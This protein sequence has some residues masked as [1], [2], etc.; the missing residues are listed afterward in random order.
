MNVERRHLTD[1]QRAAVAG[2]LVTDGQLKADEAADRV[3][4]SANQASKARRLAGHSDHLV[5][6]IRSGHMSIADGMDVIRH[7][8]SERLVDALEAAGENLTTVQRIIAEAKEA[9]AEK[10]EAQRASLTLTGDRAWKHVEFVFDTD[11]NLLG[12]GYVR[13]RAP[14][15]EDI[16]PHAL[17]ARLEDVVDRKMRADRS[18]IRKALRAELEEHELAAMYYGF[19]NVVP[20]DGM[21]RAKITSSVVNR[22]V[23]Y[24]EADAEDE[25][26]DSDDEDEDE[27]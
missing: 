7:E 6:L 8:D 17:V 13:E 2:K 11:G 26:D 16:D 24:W 15:P 22:L 20:A 1:D 4:V 27:D 10:R 21:G 25:D 19:E 12:E 23:S 9:R 18:A 14:E 3:K 5:D